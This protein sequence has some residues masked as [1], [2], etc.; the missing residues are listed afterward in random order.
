M[1]I[2]TGTCVGARAE[3]GCLMHSVH[4]DV[5]ATTMQVEA[6]LAAIEAG[7]ELAYAEGRMLLAV[8]EGDA[9]LVVHVI[10]E[11]FQHLGHCELAADALLRNRY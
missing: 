3:P 10:E 11:L 9:S 6:D 1:V 8:P 4:Q 2:V 7:A 5:A